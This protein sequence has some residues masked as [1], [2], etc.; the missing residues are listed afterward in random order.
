MPSRIPH[1]S[2][3][4]SPNPNPARSGFDRAAAVLVIGTALGRLATLAATVAVSRLVVAEQFGQLALMQTAI[5]LFAGLSGLGLSIAV[6]RQ[7]AATRLFDPAAVGRYIGS[8]LAISLSAGAVT[9]LVWLGA[10]GPIA[11]AVLRSESLSNLVLASAP[12]IMA[13]V[14]TTT[15]Q[16]A[17]VGL[18]AFRS[19]ALSQG[20]QGLGSAVG[21]IVGAAVA[22]VSGALLGFGCGHAVAGALSCAL[23]TREARRQGVRLRLG[24]SR[25]EAR[26]LGRIAL[27]ALV[28]SLAVLL[29]LFGSQLLLTAEPDGYRELAAFN[30]AYRWHLAL[31]FIPVAAAPVL[32]SMMTRFRAGGEAGDARGIYSRHIRLTVALTAVPGVVVALAAPLILS[33]HG[34]FYERYSTP[35]VVLAGAA[36]FTAAHAVISSARS[37]VG[38]IFHW[39]TSDFVLAAVLVGVAAWL[40]GGA[41]ATGLAVAYAAAYVATD[42][43]LAVPVFRRLRRA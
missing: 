5:V 21:L 20:I 29:G 4:P 39:L 14:A 43:Y 10:H 40:V 16:G 42:A 34:D 30:I 12:A 31:V 36:V 13:S 9:T 32:L 28:G 18:E 25:P 7:V 26:A 35:F 2:S 17:L 37:S 15:V 8:A 19:A 41:G 23:L 24:V 3:S 27:P 38:A 22:D 6:T 11:D 33:F 1:S